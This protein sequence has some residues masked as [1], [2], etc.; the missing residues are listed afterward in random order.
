MEQSQPQ[1]IGK[2]VVTGRGPFTARKTRS[3]V[4]RA[5]RGAKITRSAFRSV[6][7]V[8]AEGDALELAKGLY[9]ECGEKIGHATAVLAE[10]ES[11]PDSIR[12][13]A[14]KIAEEQ[15]IPDQ[16]FCFRLN[17]R[18]AHNLPDD[19]PKIEHEIGGAIYVALEQKDNRKPTVT[20][21]DPDVTIIAEVLGPSTL[22]GLLRKDWRALPLIVDLTSKMSSEE[23]VV[24]TASL[25]K[26]KA[27]I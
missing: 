23:P 24:E 5:I 26:S 17:K 1:K 19:T 2:L 4:R 14:V 6:F 7:V 22:I 11:K 13:A 16:S 27:V 9:Q 3:A 18:G 20:L 25:A 15:M 12:E 10:V 21:T 8:E